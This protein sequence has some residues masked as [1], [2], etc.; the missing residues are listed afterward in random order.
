MSRPNITNRKLD[1]STYGVRIGPRA[2]RDSQGPSPSL[3]RHAHAQATDTNSKRG[4]VS[5]HLH[6]RRSS[7]QT[8]PTRKPKDGGS[9]G[10]LCLVACALVGA[11]NTPA[12]SLQQTDGPTTRRNAP[13]NSPTLS[14]LLLT[15]R[16]PAV[17]GCSQTMADMDMLSQSRSSGGNATTIVA[18][19]CASIL[20]P[21]LRIS[22]SARRALYRRRPL[23][24]RPA[25]R[26]CAQPARKA[27]RMRA[28]DRPPKARAPRP[29]G[30]RAHGASAKATWAVAERGSTCPA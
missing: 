18:G 26:R 1:W 6:T 17:P 19:A 10:A 15:C 30:R 3:R 2:H 13:D 11:P 25:S 22:L 23:S 9:G 4:C 14:D 28:R 20:R 24:G 21:G 16:K 27:M 5:A 8:L 7:G 12:A 29:P